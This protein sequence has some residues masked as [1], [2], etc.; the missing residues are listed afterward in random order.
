MIFPIEK[1]RK[2]WATCIGNDE[3]ET[4]GHG[5]NIDALY[6]DPIGTS[7]KEVGG[8]GCILSRPFVFAFVRQEL[9]CHLQRRPMEDLR[10]TL[11]GLNLQRKEVRAICC[12]LWV[13]LRFI[14][15]AVEEM[16]D[17]L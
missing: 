3:A 11:V 7:L 12:T 16:D 2:R 1:L 5:V 9:S 15:M 8:V 17:L 14:F 13:I 10:G 4:H 6:H